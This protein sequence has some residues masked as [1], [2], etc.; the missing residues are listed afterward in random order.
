MNSFVFAIRAT[1]LICIAL[2]L[3]LG[4]FWAGLAWPAPA[5]TV[6][7]PKRVEGVFSPLPAGSVE[8]GGWLGGRLEA[9]MTNRV[10]AQ[11]IEKLVRPFQQRN[12][13]S[14]DTEYWGK[15]FTSAAF[16]YRYQPNAEHRAKIDEAVRALLKTQ[17]PDGQIT[18]FAPAQQLGKNWDLWGRKYAILGLISHY[19]VTGDRASARGR[20]AGRRLHRQPRREGHGH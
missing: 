18:G 2:S 14:W 17:G 5:G 20:Q 19:D 12:N 15:W 13:G 7:L 6:R 11:D 8:V 3:S 1:R 4:V 9:C 16:A 10:M